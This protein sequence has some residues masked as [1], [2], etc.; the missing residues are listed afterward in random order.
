M[1]ESE[2]LIELQSQHENNGPQV[3][4]ISIN[5]VMDKFA[6]FMGPYE[7]RFIFPVYSF[8]ISCSFI[9]YNFGFFLLNSMHNQQ[10]I[11]SYDNADK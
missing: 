10:F 6:Q 2:V 11:C 3:K 5:D 9:Y 1:K 4:K 7:Y 8:F